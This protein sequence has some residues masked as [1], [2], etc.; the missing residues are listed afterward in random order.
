MSDRKVAIQDDL[1]DEI[2]Y[3]RSERS[4][5]LGGP[6]SYVYRRGLKEMKEAEEEGRRT[7]AFDSTLSKVERLN[8][9]GQYAD[10]LSRLLDGIRDYGENEDVL[11]YVF[12]TVL[13]W[14]VFRGN[15]NSDS[16]GT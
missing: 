3:M 4:S 13:S 10:A 9:T 14:C 1:D 5:R 8:G 2:D 6:G 12:E 7:E 15:L 16:G 11:K